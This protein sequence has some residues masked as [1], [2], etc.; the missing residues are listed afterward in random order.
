MVKDAP[1][2]LKIDGAKVTHMV[3]KRGRPFSDDV[4]WRVYV[5]GPRKDGSVEYDP[6]GSVKKVWN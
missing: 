2:Q 6:A 3:L 5:S 1:A 4:R